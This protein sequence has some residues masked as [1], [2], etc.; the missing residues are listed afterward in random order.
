MAEEFDK[1]FDKQFE[2]VD[3]IWTDKLLKDD[4]KRKAAAA[5]GVGVPPR[6]ATEEEALKDKAFEDFFKKSGI[7]DS[8]DQKA[9]K[10]G[11]DDYLA[12]RKVTDYRDS[13]FAEIYKLAEIDMAATGVDAKDEEV[14]KALASKKLEDFFKSE[15]ITDPKE[16]ESW[17]KDFETYKKRSAEKKAKAEEAA[18][19]AKIEQLHMDI[20]DKIAKGMEPDDANKEAFEEFFKR[21]KITDPKEQEAWMEDF[22]TYFD[23]KTEREEDDKEELKGKLRDRQ[24]AGI[25]KDFGAKVA[26]GMDPRKA[27]PAALEDFFK[28][29]G[30][31]DPK[32]KEA[33]KKDFETYFERKAARGKDAAETA[34]KSGKKTL[35]NGVVSK[36]LSRNKD[37]LVLAA[38]ATLGAAWTASA[39]LSAAGMGGL[40][41]LP[42][43]Q[44]LGVSSTVFPPALAAGALLV[45]GYYV[46]KVLDARKAEKEAAK[47]KGETK[48]GPMPGPRG[49]E[50]GR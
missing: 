33:W 3:D 32:E 12:R 48:R 29:E 9:F 14:E 27:Q 15:G 47:E 42:T 4:A 37:K 11:F 17:K 18:R 24:V 16:Q 46:K 26:S 45:A 10:K 49:K 39:S 28:R 41:L 20:G 7:T 8:E 21:E 34:K 35:E 40:G 36:W 5:T 44:V 2:E 1:E 30:I 22:E 50:G 25:W 31:V 19:N 13:K 6:T 38:T 23:R 43:I